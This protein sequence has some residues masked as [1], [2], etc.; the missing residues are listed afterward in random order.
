[1]YDLF[2]LPLICFV[3]FTDHAAAYHSVAGIAVNTNYTL[4]SLTGLYFLAEMGLVGWRAMAI[5]R[6]LGAE[7]GEGRRRGDSLNSRVRFLEAMSRPCGGGGERAERR[8][9]L[10]SSTDRNGV[11]ESSIR[12]SGRKHTF[13]PYQLLLRETA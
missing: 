3:S 1:M 13:G 5:G 6:R 2:T 12:L 9:K 11:G 10:T 8:S 4:A 7:G